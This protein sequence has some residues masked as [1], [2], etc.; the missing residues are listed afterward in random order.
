MENI[1]NAKI[2]SL[3]S[4]YR[5]SIVMEF[6]TRYKSA[7][8]IVL[9]CSQQMA[10]MIVGIDGRLNSNIEW[11]TRQGGDTPKGTVEKILNVD[12]GQ[13]LGDIQRVV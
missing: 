12:G 3:N 13:N 6:L 9:V 10:N 1:G 8:V 11:K 4:T 7:G 2:V 5:D